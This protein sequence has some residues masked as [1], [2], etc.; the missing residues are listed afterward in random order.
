MIKEIFGAIFGSQNERDIKK[1]RPVV[2]KINALEPEI[3]KLSNEELKA[4]SLEFKERLNNGEKL[5]SILPEAFACVREA[6]KRTIGLRHFDVQMIGGYIL[7]Q[8]KIAEMKTG[9]G[10]TLV[11]TLPV[12]LNSLTGKGV[13]VVTVND[14]LAKRDKEWME[15]VYNALGLT[16]GNVCHDVSNE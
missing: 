16:V 13:H 15:P 14:Y 4:K 5:D 3:E 8:G 12:Y 1:I 9:E 6:S 7:H 10:K 2:N 11:A